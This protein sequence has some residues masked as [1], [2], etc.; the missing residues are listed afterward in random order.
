MIVNNESLKENLIYLGMAIS[1]DVTAVQ[2]TKMIRFESDENDVYAYTFDDINNIRV[3]IG[4]SQNAFNAIVD[5]SMFTN[6]IKSCEGD[7]KL[8]TTDKFL[9]IKAD[10]MKCK[11]PIYD[12]QNSGIPNPYNNYNY[13]KE[14]DTFS[15]DIHAIK[16]IIDPNHQVELYRKVYF[17]DNILVTDADNVLAIH[18]KIFDRDIILELSSVEMLSRLT[19]C[20]Y[21]F[22]QENRLLKLCINS[23]ELC[24]TIVA[25]EDSNNEYQYDDF[26]ELFDNVTGNSVDIEEHILSKAMN[27]SQLFKIMPNIVFNQKG[28]FLQI[29]SSGFVYKIC[30]TVCEDKIFELTPNI[31]KILHSLG[32]TITIYYTNQD[33]IKCEVDGRSEILSIKEITNG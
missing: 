15:I 33:L 1:K 24:A 19:N 9:N 18:T 7:I 17:G 26:I 22:I 4:T 31:V 21:T 12:R 16:S 29:E 25:F 3:K 13:D 11:L 2:R 6:F 20:K 8:E 32:T 5:Y 27:A 28:V 30:D 14:L 23:N 10:N